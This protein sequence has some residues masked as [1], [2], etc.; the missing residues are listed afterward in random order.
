MPTKSASRREV[1]LAHADIHEFFQSE[2][3][4]H[5]DESW[6]KLPVT[7]TEEEERLHNVPLNYFL[8]AFWD[9]PASV[10]KIKKAE[11]PTAQATLA[12]LLFAV[13]SFAEYLTPHALEA[14]I[15]RLEIAVQDIHSREARISTS[16]SSISF[17]S[18]LARAKIF[19][20]LVKKTFEEAYGV[21][22]KTVTLSPGSDE[23]HAVLVEVDA[24]SGDPSV[25]EKMRIEGARTTFYDRLLERIPP[26]DFDLLSFEFYFPNK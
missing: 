14:R 13:S 19:L 22:A 15:Q 23:G 26:A 5:P 10:T 16:H 7:G 12:S 2:V 4:G 17:A 6:S 9:E 3:R 24:S 1:F 18:A 8:R 11:S 21:E 25:L 20:P